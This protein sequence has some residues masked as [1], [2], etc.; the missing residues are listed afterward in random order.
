MIKCVYALEAELI[1]VAT[2]AAATVCEESGW[3]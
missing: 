2:D 3:L 1:A